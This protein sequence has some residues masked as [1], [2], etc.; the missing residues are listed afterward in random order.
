[1][2]KTGIATAVALCVVAGV[3]VFRQGTGA[4]AAGRRDSLQGT[5]TLISG[6]AL[7]EALTD[8]QL[9]DGKL[10]IT[11]D[12]YRVTLE[13]H[14]TTTGLQKLDESLSP[15]TID[16]TPDSGPDKGQ[17]FLG[18]YQVAGDEFRIAIAP[19]GD[20]RPADFSTAADSG[21]WTHTWKRVSE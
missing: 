13:G 17:S 8:Q 12:R 4:E 10:V 16:I 21:R 11:G 1:M 20:N 2:K 5:W 6:E 18:I 19:P 15:R 7:G 14:G 9:Q 3:L